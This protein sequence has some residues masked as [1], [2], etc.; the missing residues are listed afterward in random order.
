[1]KNEKA[2]LG[3]MVLF[4]LPFCAVGVITAVLAFREATSSPARWGE[5]GFLLIFALVFGG[6]VSV[7]FLSSSQAGKAGPNRT[8]E[9]QSS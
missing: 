4:A 1:M 7:C 2:A 8:P 3:W 6:P 5:A 9:K